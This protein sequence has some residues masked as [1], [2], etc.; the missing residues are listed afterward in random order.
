MAGHKH[1]DV[2]RS[3]MTGTAEID[4]VDGRQ[5]LRIEHGACPALIWCGLHRGDVL[6]ARTVTGFA[7]DP[8]DGVFGIKIS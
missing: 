4:R 5:S 3:A 1:G 2:D 7:S 6:K 8:E